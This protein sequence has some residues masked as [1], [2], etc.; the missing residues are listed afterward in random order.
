[1][2]IKESFRMSVRGLC[3]GLL[4]TASVLRL[5]AEPSVRAG[6]QQTAAKLPDTEKLTQLVLLLGMG[7][8][9]SEVEP[10]AEPAV[11]AGAET[12]AETAVCAEY[13]TLLYTP[14]ARSVTI[15][16][17]ED[18]SLVDIRNRA[19]AEFDA[20]ALITQPTEFDLAADGPLILIVHTHATEA[21]TVADGDNYEDMGNY[22]TADTS[23]NV[24]RV[25]QVL[26]DALNARGIETL[27]DTTLNDLAGYNDSYT[28][29][30]EVIAQYLERYPGIQMVIDV[31][32]DALEDT[33]GNQLAVTKQLGGEDFA[34]LM[35]VMGTDCGGLEHPNWE[36]NLSF[37]LKVQAFAEQRETGVFRTMSLRAQRYNQQYTPCSI[38]LEVGTAGNTLRQ[39]TRSAE[40]FAQLLA[41]LLEAECAP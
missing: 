25:G 28:R 8:S 35:L 39:A 14:P 13:P 38:L 40:W 9:P 22:H 2:L 3:F 7:T 17:A 41:D 30:A 24:V 26:A 27:H 20:G 32:R 29:S 18:A 10:T 19:E 31:H 4:L 1:M 23:Y 15:F 11:E 33:D 12:D 21:Y 5:A 34:R 37:A 6:L 16:S 36:K